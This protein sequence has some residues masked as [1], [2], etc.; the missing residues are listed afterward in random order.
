MSATVALSPLARHLDLRRQG[1]G[2]ELIQG[3]EAEARRLDHRSLYASTGTSASLLERCGWQLVEHV[4]H[5]G[6]RLG[7]FEK[8]L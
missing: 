4:E 6:Q 3:L 1:I 2:R 7:V 8:T 5:D